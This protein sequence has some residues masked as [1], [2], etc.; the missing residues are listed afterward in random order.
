MPSSPSNDD[1]VLYVGATSGSLIKG[2]TYQYSSSSTSWIDISPKSDVDQSYDA[3]STNAQSGVA[4]A[5]AV[6]SATADCVKTSGNQ[7]INGIKIFNDKIRADR[8]V[9]IDGEGVEGS[10]ELN[11]GSHIGSVKIEAPGDNSDASINVV[12]GNNN[13]SHIDINADLVKANNKNVVTSVNSTQAD[14]GGNVTLSIPTI[15][16]DGNTATITY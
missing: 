7:E 15:T 12:G 16:V 6:L 3:T 8:I 5:S 11:T 13:E 4:V 2:H 9:P 14:D 1:I 10:I